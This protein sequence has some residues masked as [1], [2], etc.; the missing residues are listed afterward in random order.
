MADTITRSEDLK[1]TNMFMD[2]D[3]RVITIKNARS[4]IE[5]SELTDLNTWMLTNQVIVGDKT[6][7]AFARIKSVAKVTTI[8]RY[9]DFS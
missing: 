1:I 9:L 7:A 2:G 6:G 8:D 5:Q 3:T 4:D